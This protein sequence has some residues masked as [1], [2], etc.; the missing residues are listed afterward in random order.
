MAKKNQSPAPPRTSV[1]D[2]ELAIIPD[3]Q[4]MVFPE[5]ERETVK[6]VLVNLQR[7]FDSALKAANQWMTLSP[8]S[9]LK[10]RQMSPQLED[11]WDR[12]DAVGRGD[13]HPRLVAAPGKTAALMR[14]MPIDMQTHYLVNKFEVA[15]EGGDSMMV[16]LKNMTLD[17]KRQVL[18][19]DRNAG[20]VR[21][22]SLAEQ[23]AWLAQQ[24]RDRKAK[25]A[26]Q[27]QMKKEERPG[28]YRIEKKRGFI[29]PE[30]AADGLTFAEAKDFYEAFK[31]CMK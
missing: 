29:D 27:N 8:E 4:L 14:K 16:D 21:V 13:L 3:E 19:F 30:K 26:R 28:L 24:E 1:I 31:R 5:T 10:I 12:L 6:S 22:R 18:D 11:T 7:L 23:R 9:R 25:E 20:T 17:Y 15:L 2:A